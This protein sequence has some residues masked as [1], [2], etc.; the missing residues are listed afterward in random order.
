MY[1]FRCIYEFFIYRVGLY[2]IKL[3]AFLQD[4]IKNSLT[5]KNILA[6]TRFLK[7]K[8]ISLVVIVISRSI[9]NT[10]I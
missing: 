3:V 1:T 2:T 7:K 10:Y 4:A 8:Y 9:F 5:I 6:V